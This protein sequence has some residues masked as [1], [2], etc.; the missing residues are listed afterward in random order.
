MTLNLRS[1]VILLAIIPSLLLAA[2]ISSST[3]WVLQKLA[4]E[5]VAQTRELLINERKTS[6]KHYMEIAQASIQPIY[7]AS[8]YGDFKARDQAVTILRTLSFD[9]QNYFYGYDSSSV[10]VF[11]SN[12]NTDIGKSFVDTLEDSGKAKDF[13][14]VYHAW[15]YNLQGDLTVLR[16]RFGDQKRRRQQLANTGAALHVTL[17]GIKN[18]RH[19]TTAVTA[20]ADNRGFAALIASA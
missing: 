8:H 7:D 14:C 6:L 2:I 13:T 9:K 18:I 19:A 3:F 12:L 11:S 5:E 1:K 16:H 15:S 10:R 20:P 4:S 17:L